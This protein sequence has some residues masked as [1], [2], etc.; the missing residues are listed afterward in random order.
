MRQSGIESDADLSALIEHPPAEADEEAVRQLRSMHETAAWVLRESALADLPSDLRWLFENAALTVEQLAILCETLGLVTAG[1]LAAA[2]R[3]H[4]ISEA[5]HL[6]ADIEHAVLAALPTL[7]AAVPRI[8]L[9]RAA[10][11]AERVRSAVRAVSGVQWAVPAG[12][13]RRAQ[14]TVGD[15]ELVAAA[16]DP[17]AVIDGVVS[18]SEVTRVLHRA[19]RRVSVRHERVQIGV[20]VPEP[21]NA[22]AVLVSATGS[23]RHIEALGAHAAARGWRLSAQGLWRGDGVFR[24]SGSEEELYAALDLPF[25]APELRETGDEVAA[26][27]RGELPPL[28][29]R[30][31]IRGDLHMHSDFSDGRDPVAA[32]VAAC[33]ALG[34]SYI[35]I[36]DHSPHSSASRNLS[37]DSIVKQADQIA[38]LRE[39]YAGM[40]ILHGCEV[41]ILP[42][43]RLDFPDKV[44]ERLDI[45]LASLHE[46]AG[47]A[48]DQLL[49]RYEAAMK[50]PLVAL[51]THPTN[52]MVPHKRGYELDYDRLFES[53]VATGTIVEVD[54]SPAH[55]D[56]DGAL[57][58]R[59][60]AAGAA[61]AIN[62]DCH[63]ADLLGA[64]MELG[65][66][67]A[68]RG[69]IEPRHVVNTKPLADVQAVIAA[70]RRR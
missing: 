15:I 54:G 53:A 16:A 42:N 64:Q 8:A 3:D 50:H 26:A 29:T 35:A 4:T 39:R 22:G 7:R 2:L 28:V 31:D 11:I 34:Y 18:M 23:H 10:A 58:R 49:R 44:L 40:V 1:D 59:A 60:A 57:A 48:P 33:H 70:K 21:S 43:G 62:S 46:R 67:T 32:M 69:W 61:I 66:A 51:I 41:D 6:G 20:R 12:S 14:E 55:L 19:D 30:A 52:R 38:E 13:L 68:R 47:H 9:G 56:L 5:P 25:I 36:T 63:R 37:V 17:A 24:P 27:Y 65:V 45:V